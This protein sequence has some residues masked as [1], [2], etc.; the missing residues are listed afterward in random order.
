MSCT[1]RL[2]M[3]TPSFA[4]IDN[5]YTAPSSCTWTLT[6]PWLKQWH[7]YHL[8]NCSNTSCVLGDFHF[9]HLSPWLFVAKKVVVHWLNHVHAH[10]SDIKPCVFNKVLYG[11][12]GLHILLWGQILGSFTQTE[13]TH[14]KCIP[15]SNVTP[16]CNYDI[17][18]MTSLLSIW[19]H[20]W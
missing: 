20:A 8:Y 3:I 4:I 13:M 2:C 12:S 10:V 17:I 6:N 11:I 7:H 16:P 5:R 14:Y 18:M 1:C 9:Q 19:L 15:Y